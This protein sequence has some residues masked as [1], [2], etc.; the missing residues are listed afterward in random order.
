MHQ[1]VTILVL[2]EMSLQYKYGES[3]N[4]K[5]NVTILVLVEMSL[6]FKSHLVIIK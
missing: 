4:N 5:R 3:N 6:Q 2:V 1:N